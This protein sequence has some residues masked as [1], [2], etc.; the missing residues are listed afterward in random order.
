MGGYYGRIHSRRYP[1][2]L[3]PF[4]IMKWRVELCV[5][6]EKDSEAYLGSAIGRGKVQL[7]A[8]F[9]TEIEKT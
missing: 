8:V 5:G 4:H 3:C 6:L 2:Y 7:I 1:V 9:P